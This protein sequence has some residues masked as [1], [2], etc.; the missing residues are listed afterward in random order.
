MRT[1]DKTAPKK[2]KC[3]RCDH[4]SHTLNLFK[5]HKR[6]HLLKDKKYAEIENPVKCSKCPAH[7]KNEHA[8][9]YHMMNVHPKDVCHCD[10][11]GRIIRAKSNMMK[12]IRIH[13]RNIE[14]ERNEKK[15]STFF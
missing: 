6:S 10:L 11:C 14:R 13:L 7:L 2:Y 1:H 12:H 5:V 9:K 15:E 4:A 3:D 8:L